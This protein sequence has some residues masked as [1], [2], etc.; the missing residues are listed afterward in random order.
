ML[1]VCAHSD[2]H[3]R[4]VDTTLDQLMDVRVDELVTSA[5]IAAIEENKFIKSV[6]SLKR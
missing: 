3:T 2:K 5:L 4:R 6:F 1:H